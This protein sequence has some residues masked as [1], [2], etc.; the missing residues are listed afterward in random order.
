MPISSRSPDLY[1]RGVAERLEAPD[2]IYYFSA[3]DAP[4]SDPPHALVGALKQCGF[5]VVADEEL[6]GDGFWHVAAIDRGGRTGAVPDELR[7]IASDHGASYDGASD[8][9]NRS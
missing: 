8:S 5:E 4:G 1:G 9:R 7:R 3:F 6:S 2:T